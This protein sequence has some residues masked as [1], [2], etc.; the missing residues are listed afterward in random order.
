MRC[1][2][3][4]WR[5]MT[6]PNYSL[7]KPNVR[8]FC[9]PLK[10]YFYIFVLFFI[11]FC[12]I[13]LEWNSPKRLKWF[14]SFL[15]HIFIRTFCSGIFEKWVWK[16]ELGVD[17]KGPTFFVPS[18][19]STGTPHTTKIIMAHRM[20]WMGNKK[21]CVTVNSVSASLA[22]TH[23]HT[24]PADTHFPSKCIRVFGL[25]FWPL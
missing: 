4:G 14:E 24:S 10:L 25:V 12:C 9:F 20:W 3:N 13:I 23:T 1:I 2:R 22:H 18:M 15:A 11:S 17:T 16:R 21:L 5:N 19:G 7:E 8:L 6:S